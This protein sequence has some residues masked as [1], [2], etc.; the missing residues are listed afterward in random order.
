[1][2]AVT[3]VS[4][5]FN[6]EK[7]IA[8]T[9]DSVL[10]QTTLDYEYIIC[11]GLSKD[12]TVEIAQSYQERFA[13]KGISYRV[14]SQKDAGIFDAMNKGIDLAN[15][16]YIFFLNAGDWFCDNYALSHFVEAIREDASP[17][18]YYADYCYVDYHRATRIATD[19]SLL[20]QK[21]SIGHPA[22]AARTD[23]MRQMHFDTQYRIAA[24]YNFVLGLKMQGLKFQHLNTTS[25]YFLSG[26]ISGKTEKTN[27]EVRRIHESYGLPHEDIVVRP[28]SR[29]QKV[30]N[31][32]VK[33]IPTW[34]WRFYTE[35]IKHGKWIEY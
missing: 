30:I 33:G 25:S 10:K 16:Q 11:D 8:R 17:A 14:Y 3:I 18:V 6:E 32:V 23:L 31:A 9:I 4:V 12:R 28:L 21:M 24:D 1:M 20:P 2:K 34:L 7:N 13:Q 5:C 15:G 27:I 26:G 35:K 19:D 29:K 22:M